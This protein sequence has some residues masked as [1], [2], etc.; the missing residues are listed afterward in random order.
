MTQRPEFDANRVATIVSLCLLA[1]VTPSAVLLGPLIIGGLV[2]ERAGNSERGAIFL[3][4]VPVL[5]HLF[6]TTNKTSKREELLIFIQPKIINSNDPL[7]SPNNIE[8]KRSH[9]LEETI[10]FGMPVDQIPRALPMT[11]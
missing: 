4:R 3:R 2:T 10:R 8:A 1:S 11:K 9:I 7:D 6:G 5:K